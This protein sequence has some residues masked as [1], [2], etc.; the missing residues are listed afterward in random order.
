MAVCLPIAIGAGLCSGCGERAP[1]V[2]HHDPKN[3]HRSSLRTARVS[4]NPARAWAA[5]FHIRVCSDVWSGPRSGGDWGTA[6]NWSLKRVPGPGDMA[7]VRRGVTLTLSGGSYVVGSLIDGGSLTITTGSLV[8]W[9]PRVISQFGVMRVQHEGRLTWRGV[10][11]GGTLD[12]AGVV[13][14]GTPGANTVRHLLAC[15]PGYTPLII[16]SDCGPRFSSPPTPGMLRRIWSRFAQLVNEAA[17]FPTNAASVEASLPQLLTLPADCAK[18]P[19]CHEEIARLVAQ[20]ARH[21]LNASLTSVVLGVR[22]SSARAGGT[23][24][25]FAPVG[26]EWM[27]IQVIAPEVAVR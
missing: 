12:D 5:R 17:D 20:A 18:R 19:A 22:Q 14:A 15:L 13:N 11:D 7:C 24:V 4:R 8:I 3:L 21:P 10:V 1:T 16:G 26:S 23:A 9:N 27:I 25:R 2:S 6:R